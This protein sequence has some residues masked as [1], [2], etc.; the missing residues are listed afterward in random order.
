[1]SRLHTQTQ[2]LQTQLASHLLA[3]TNASTRMPSASALWDALIS[4]PDGATV[5]LVRAQPPPD[6]RQA[7]RR[8]S[9]SRAGGGKENTAQATAAA[10][11]R[12][13][14][15]LAAVMDGRGRQPPS[16]VRSHD[17]EFFFAFEQL[18]SFAG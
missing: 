12:R 8:R 4:A 2:A 10:L 9:H 11:T 14:A 7:P 1:M 6:A 3:A 17:L 5:A 16:N 15:E 13:V 18:I